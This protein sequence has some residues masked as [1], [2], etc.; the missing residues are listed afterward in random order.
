MRIIGIINAASMT[1][2]RCFRTNTRVWSGIPKASPALKNVYKNQIPRDLL[3]MSRNSTKSRMI[4]TAQ[5]CAKL[6]YS[7][8]ANLLDTVLLS[9]H[10]Y[11]C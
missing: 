2:I 7:F 8:T 4:I 5:A 1:M 10:A 11:S 9:K 6:R 3:V